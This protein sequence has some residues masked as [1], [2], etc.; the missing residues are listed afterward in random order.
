MPT[1]TRRLASPTPSP[2]ECLEARYGAAQSVAAW[3]HVLVE[4]RA[5]NRCRRPV[6][7]TEV[8]FLVSGFRDGAPV[9]T[10]RG[11][12]FDTIFPGRSETFSIGLPGSIDFYDQIIVEIED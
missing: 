10:V 2:A 1:P 6:A 3:G 11:H 7:P 5:T 8:S 4:I 9:R 12:P